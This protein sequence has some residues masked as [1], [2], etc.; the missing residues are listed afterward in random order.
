MYTMIIRGLCLGH[1]IL[2]ILSMEKSN[3]TMN[4]L[5]TGFHGFEYCAIAL[6]YIKL[7]HRYPGYS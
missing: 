3:K 7:H 4:Y 5:R 2:I 6:T 1:Y